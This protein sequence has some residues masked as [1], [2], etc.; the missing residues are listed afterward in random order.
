MGAFLLGF[1]RNSFARPATEVAPDL[2]GWEL[3][4]ANAAGEAGGII[5]ETEAY[6]GADDPASHAF[7]GPSQRN[8][9]MFGPP[10][11]AY[12]YFT[13]G[14]HYCLNVVTGAAGEAS[15]VLIRALEPTRGIELM[16]QRRGVKN[17]TNLT[18]GPAKL[19]QALGLDRAL[20]G[21]D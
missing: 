8:Q 19:T 15:A 14:L 1:D 21:H 12:V 17:L 20:N 2:L 9:V 6:M 4:F 11:Y 7:R 3:V 5:T 16:Q 13:Y 18:T 10:G